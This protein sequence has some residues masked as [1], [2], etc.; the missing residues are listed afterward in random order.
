[1]IRHVSSRYCRKY[2][3]KKA[4]AQIRFLHDSS[5]SS[6]TFTCTAGI[7]T[8]SIRSVGTFHRNI[9][10]EHMV[11]HC[12]RLFFNDKFQSAEQEN[13]NES[14]IL[15]CSMLTRDKTEN[16]GKMIITKV[17]N[18]IIKHA[19][20]IWDI[21]MVL[22]RTS[23]ITL[24]FAPLII[25]APAAILASKRT[26]R[27]GDEVSL[28]SSKEQ[29]NNRTSVISDAAWKYTLYTIQKLGPAF[30]KISQW[31]S[32]RRDIFPSDACDRLSELNDSVFLHSW[33]HTHRTL[34]NTFGNDYEDVLKI[35]KDGIIGSGSVAQVYSGIWKDP[36]SETKEGRKVAVKVL[37]PNIHH[38]V[39]RDLL[40]LKRVANIIRKFT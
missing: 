1:M 31:A 18:E 11:L 33:D 10:H 30:I 29:K 15:S 23:E 6:P 2:L 4:K 16:G 38:D 40:L 13:E 26:G 14:R 17:M 34:I 22:L 35:D 12:N 9:L 28:S 20:A 19:K 25:L 8:I 27:G 3:V 21:L 5:S 36:N 32:T 37:H 24:R 7:R 39:E